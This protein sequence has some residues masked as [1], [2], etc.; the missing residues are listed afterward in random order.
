LV[1]ERRPA[2]EEK[3]FRSYDPE[4]V[5]LLPPVLSEWV[6]DGHLAHFVSDLVESGC[7]IYRRFMP[8]TRRSG[9][10]RRMTRV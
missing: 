9:A 6:P 2:A 1:E 7:S 10:I 5:L 3:T 8:P 4:Q